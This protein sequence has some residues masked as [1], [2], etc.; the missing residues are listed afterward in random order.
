MIAEKLAEDLGYEGNIVS[1]FR[2]AAPS[3]KLAAL[4]FRR[5]LTEYPGLKIVAEQPYITLNGAD[6]MAKM[7]SLLIA[8]PA[9]ATLTPS[10]RCSTCR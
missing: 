8:N 4:N 7:E 5:F 10:G 3:R 6:A 1:F 9:R 2:P